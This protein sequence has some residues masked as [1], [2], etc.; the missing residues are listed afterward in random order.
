MRSA[1]K[2]LTTALV[3]VAMDNGAPFDVTTP[4]YSLFPQYDT[5]AHDDPRKRRIT[6]E[7]L[8]TMTSGF[9]CDDD[10]DASP[11]NEDNMQD[12]VEQPDWY[13][14]ALDLPMLREAGEKSVYCSA[15]INLLG[16]VISNTTSTWLP[17]FVHEHW[18]LPLDFGRYHLV[19]MPGEFG[20]MYMGGGSYLRPRDFMKLGQVFLA[21]GRWNGRQVVSK[22]W[23][24]RSLQPHS[25]LNEP[26]DYGYGWH[27][28]EY[29]VAGQTYH[30]AEAGGNGGQFVIIMPELDMVVMFTAA[31]YGD[32]RTWSK[33]R[34]ELVPKFIIPAVRQ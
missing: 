15:G 26:D 32:Y 18:A 30:R 20:N 24:E 25:S 13:K 5:L 22:E 1:S 17:D 12:Q 3:G 7:H 27:F 19:L 11:G 9:E 33:F 16:G 28:G 2:T 8:L 4:V 34:D 6:V 10:D 29:N 21:G 14:Y 23:V 31:N